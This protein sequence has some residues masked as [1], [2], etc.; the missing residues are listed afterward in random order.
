MAWF[1]LTSANLS[2]AAWGHV[3]QSPIDKRIAI[4]S[5]EAGV[6]FL[7]KFVVK[8]DVFLLDTGNI[9]I[10]EEDTKRYFPFPYDLPLTPYS[11]TDTPFFFNIFRE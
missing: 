11:K 1:H 9:E 5:Y 10:S 7:P 8:E 4:R 2:K 3:P 6:L